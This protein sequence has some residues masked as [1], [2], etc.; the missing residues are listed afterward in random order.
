MGK[1]KNESIINI[2]PLI[3]YLKT[4]DIQ[5][6]NG[7]DSNFK[8][9]LQKAVPRVAPK[10]TQNQLSSNV[11]QMLVEHFEKDLNFLLLS[12]IKYIKN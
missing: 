8:S 2:E 5:H 3:D 11:V 4:R 7:T 6:V 10:S 1:D 9:A 12:V